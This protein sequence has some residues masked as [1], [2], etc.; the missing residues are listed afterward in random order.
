ME[1]SEER[2]NDPITLRGLDD[3]LSR[4][5]DSQD[6]LKAKQEERKIKKEIASMPP[7]AFSVALMKS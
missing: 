4:L 7:S 1:D 6:E 5:R 3:S 2:P